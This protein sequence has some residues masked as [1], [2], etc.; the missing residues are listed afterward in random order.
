MK[1]IK[2]KANDGSILTAFA[3]DK[4]D[5]VQIVWAK[6]TTRKHNTDLMIHY[7]MILTSL[8]GINLVDSTIDNTISQLS[9]EDEGYFSGWAADMQDESKHGQTIS[10]CLA[11]NNSSHR[12]WDYYKQMVV[13]KKDLTII[14]IH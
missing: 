5:D 7:S 11:G 13:D 10:V 6:S 2:Y 3:C 4:S 1:E 12:V 14:N 8:D 9:E